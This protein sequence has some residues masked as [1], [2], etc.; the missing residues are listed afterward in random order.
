[1]G[2]MFTQEIYA[3]EEA[4]RISS[5][6]T[7]EEDHEARQESRNAMNMTPNDLR[8]EASTCESS[9]TQ[10]KNNEAWIARIQALTVKETTSKARMQ[11]HTNKESHEKQPGRKPGPNRAE[12]GLGRPAQPTLSR[13]VAPYALGLR[14][15]IAFSSVRRHIEQIILPTPFTGKLPPQDEGESWMSSSLGSTQAEGRKQEE[16]CK[17]LAYGC[18]QASSPPS[19]LT[20]F[21]GVFITLM[22]F[23]PCKMMG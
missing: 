7:L 10:P 20:T 8:T 6:S 18:S 19:S 14:L 22:C 21:S 13:F 17:P 23:N 11:V 16:D 5:P 12:T 2:E 1:M 3:K 15:F 9:G 4:F